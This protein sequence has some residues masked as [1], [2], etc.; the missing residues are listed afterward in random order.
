MS[1]Q[2]DNQPTEARQPRPVYYEPDHEGDTLDT[3]TGVLALRGYRLTSDES[4]LAELGVHAMVTVEGDGSWTVQDGD[5]GTNLPHVEAFPNPVCYA[6]AIAE[7]L[8]GDTKYS[9][10]EKAAASMAWAEHAAHIGHYS[11]HIQERLADLARLNGGDPYAYR[12]G[13]PATTAAQ[14]AR[15]IV[16]DAQ[17]LVKALGGES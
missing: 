6:A 10:E 16:E 11:K 14:I 1:K 15:G 2:N 8:D 3:I 13:S 5:E 7:W 4:W 12:S 17:R 9:P